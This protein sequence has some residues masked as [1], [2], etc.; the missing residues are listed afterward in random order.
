[1]LKATWMQMLKATWMQKLLIAV[2]CVAVLALT[3]AGLLAMREPRGGDVEVGVRRLGERYEIKSWSCDRSSVD[4]AWIVP[5]GSPD[6][7]WKV[8]STRPNSGDVELTVGERPDGFEQT[9]AMTSRMD[10]GQA[11]VVVVS[12]ASRRRAVHEFDA[13]ALEL[14]RWDAI[15]GTLTDQE[16]DA[17]ESC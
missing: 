4:E 5:A 1:M 17:L 2:G 6:V 12:F 8:R 3:S 15:S 10:L 9:T 14:D 13:S 7:L 11:Y 16:F